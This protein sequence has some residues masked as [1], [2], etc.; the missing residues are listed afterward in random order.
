MTSPSYIDDSVRSFLV[1]LAATSPEPAGGSALALAAASAAALMSLTCSDAP[2]GASH[3]KLAACLAASEHLREG[4]QA[5][6][7]ADVHAYRQVRRALGLPRGDA[8]RTRVRQKAL[9]AALVEAAEVPLT[10]AQA[11][12]EVL[13]LSIDAAEAAREAVL[14]DLAAA[15]HL[16]EAAIRGSLRNARINAKAVES[17][18]LRGPLL[19]KAATLDSRLEHLARE[20]EQALRS[21]GLVE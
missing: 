16:A 10:V 7:D 18:E 5:L 19:A 2:D 17:P 6:I 15:I 1:K 4:V 3:P 12:L 20:A 8:A 13:G 14:G 11:G 9:D 21:R